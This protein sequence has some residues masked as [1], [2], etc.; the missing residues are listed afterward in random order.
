MSDSFVTQCPHC[1]TRFRVTHHQL[2]VARGVVRCGA[3]MQMFNAAKQLLE[4]H[5]AQSEAVEQPGQ[6]PALD[7]PTPAS[8]TPAPAQAV[9]PAHDWTHS[10]LDEVDLDEELARLEQ[11]DQ[12]AE[13]RA[14]RQAASLHAR[15]DDPRAEPQDERP[16]GTASDDDHEPVPATL[17]HDDTLPHE[18]PALL[19][20]DEPT[21]SLD[22]TVDTPVE[23]DQPRLGDLRD[24]AEPS[25]PLGSLSAVDTPEADD[26]LSA[27]T[28]TPDD[29]DR[30]EPGL[31]QPLPET[32]RKEPLIHVID[33]PLRLDWQK[34][35]PNWR[36]RILWGVLI[37]L[38]LAG[39]ALQYVIYHFDALARQDQYRPLFQSL[40]PAFGCQVPTRVD[41]DRIKSSNL[42]V[43]S[44]P[45][46]KGA[47]I[48]DAIIYNRASFAQPFPLLE[49]RFADLNGQLI[50]SRRF[51]PT[52]Y[53]SGELAGR[54]DMPSQ[55]PIHIALDILD[56]GPNAVNYSL[57]FRSP[58]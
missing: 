4:A 33:D 45:D 13:T 35:K 20:R 41:I 7:A 15:R 46:F 58:Q 3:C 22:A 10:T 48:V 36:K 30:I 23:A 32:R 49:L 25:V 27:H 1:Q 6:A 18:V 2:G 29:A 19:E 16:F 56:P 8:V 26:R 40:C 47:L 37:L 9:A 17:E 28:L 44:H 43:R 42:V 53:L 21:L 24:T 52:E 55:T 50:A 14:P 5:R 31:G 38:A 11:R 39:L 57:S 54:G 51:K 34:P 12:P